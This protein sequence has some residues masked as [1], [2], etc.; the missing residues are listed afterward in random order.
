[1]GQL[2]IESFPKKRPNITLDQVL[3]FEQEVD[4]TPSNKDIRLAIDLAKQ[5]NPLFKF[6]VREQVDLIRRI[7]KYD[8]S[9]QKILSIKPFKQ[10]LFK[11]VITS[12]KYKDGSYRI[13]LIRVRRT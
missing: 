13:K 12:I 11:E 3:C 4:Y 9:E 7:C 6:D 2:T 8:V 5:L 1:M 10:I